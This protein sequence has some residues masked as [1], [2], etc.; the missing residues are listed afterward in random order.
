[1]KGHLAEGVCYSQPPALGCRWQREIFGCSAGAGMDGR[2]CQ[3]DGASLLLLMIMLLVALSHN[4][5]ATTDA[6]AVGW[7]RRHQCIADGRGCR[8]DDK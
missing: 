7:R 3:L 5:T 4:I 8:S 1:M 2:Q 6:E